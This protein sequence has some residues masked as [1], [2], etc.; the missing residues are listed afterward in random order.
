MNISPVSN[1]FYNTNYANKT[2]NRQNFKGLL[3]DYEEKRVLKMLKP[4]VSKTVICKNVDDLVDI[5]DLLG[6]KYEGSIGIIP[7]MRTERDYCFKDLLSEEQVTKNSCLC[8]A[9]GDK[10]GPMETWNTAREAILV[11]MPTREL[12]KSHVFYPL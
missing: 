6:E 10:Y 11:V 7:I 8:V 1:R 5:I 4:A 12:A 2:N 9:T 3:N